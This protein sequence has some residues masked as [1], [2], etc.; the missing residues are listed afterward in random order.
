MIK[1]VNIQNWR[2]HRNST[3]DFETGT[4]VL[5]GVMGS[6]KTSV[7]DSICYALFGTFP[8]LNARKVSTEETIM[9]KPNKADNASVALEFAY[10]G[11]PYRVE[12]KINRQGANTAKLYEDG[13]L[14]AGPKPTEVTKRIEDI[15]EVNYELFSRA[16]YAEQNQMDYFLRISPSQRKEK[17][18]ELLEINKYEKVRANCVTLKTRISRIIDDRKKFLEQQSSLASKEEIQETLKKIKN[19]EEETKELEIKKKKMN[20]GMEKAKL[21]LKELEKGEKEFREFNEQKLKTEAKIESLQKEAMKT[22]DELKGRTEKDIEKERKELDE[23]I[24]K[25]KVDKKTAN[26]VREKNEEM[27]NK[28][29]HTIGINE[30]KM[31]QINDILPHLESRHGNCPVCM[32]EFDGELRNEL[33]KKNSKKME[34]LKNENLKMD[35]ERRQL[36]LSGSKNKD[37]VKL[38]DI[39]IEGLQEKK[40]KFNSVLQNAK[41]MNELKGEREKFVDESVIISKKIEKLD[42]K[43]SDLRNFRDLFIKNQGEISKLESEINSASEIVK[44]MNSSLEKMR[45]SAKKIDKMKKSVQNLES[46]TSNIDIFINALI[47]TQSQMRS[48]LIDTVN[49]AMGD[50]WPRIYPYKDLCS[51]RIEVKEGSYEVMV[52]ESSGNWIRAEG[53]LSG[54]ERSAVA[55]TLRVAISLVLTQNLSYLILDEPTHNLD[56]KAVG[57]L[58]TLTREHLP[59]LVN[60]VF[61]ITHDKEMERAASGSL[62]ILDRKKETDAPT[63]VIKGEVVG[64]IE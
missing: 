26:E 46:L 61:I 31:K 58:S 64:V 6:G 20:I 2:A 11:M 53:I 29:I 59:G 14:V 27:Y 62:Y 17:L 41:R 37:K 39:E 4:N 23:S 45:D 22:S 55:L 38:L 7:M 57:E 33:K 52:K 3:F 16:V 12:R 50:I 10:G 49:Q 60:Q 8:S 48:Q 24:E 51:A 56:R 30:Q 18:D 19:K 9:A 1:S 28:M 36:I 32:K 43:E 5:V 34:D 25:C 15:I 44:E 35:E 54:G 63:E 40:S 21:K 13:R 47:S 42:F